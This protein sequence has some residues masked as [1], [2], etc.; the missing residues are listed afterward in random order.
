MPPVEGA[1]GFKL[2]DKPHKNPSVSF[3][4]FH[5]SCSLHRKFSMDIQRHPQYSVYALWLHKE[6]ICVSLLY[7]VAEG[8]SL[9]WSLPLLILYILHFLRPIFTKWLKRSE[10][11]CCWT[12]AQQ[13]ALPAWSQTARLHQS[14]RAWSWT[15]RLRGWPWRPPEH[16]HENR[17]TFMSRTT[18]E[19]LLPDIF[20]AQ[21]AEC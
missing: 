7:K 15:S 13:V 18:V 6:K 12:K 4:A 3:S 2:R 16:L 14:R 21:R 20:C 17:N 10:R 11:R 19:S 1:T 5:I 9:N 8:L